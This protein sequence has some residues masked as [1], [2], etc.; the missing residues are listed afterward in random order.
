MPDG[1]LPALKD[2]WFDERAADAAC[3]F[4]P[5]YLRH[6]EAEWAGRPFELADYQREDII[7][8]L[9]GWK[10]PDGTRRYRQAYFE[11]PRKNG[12]SELLAGISILA[13][14]G[15]REFGAQGYA[16]ACD[17]DQ[18]KIVFGKASTMVGM[19]E[20]LLDILEVYKPSIYCPEIMGSFKPMSK[21][22]STKHGFSP[23]FI[24]GDELHEWV[25]RGLYEVFHS[26]IGARR[27]PLEV[28][29]T[30]AGVYGPSLCWEFHER[31]LKA[32]EHPELDPSFL[33]VI[34]AA[35]PD[36]DWTDPKVWAKANPNL[37]V[38]PKLEAIAAA[39]DEARNSPRLEN[40][41]RRLH[42][43]Q[44]T[45]Q[46]TR[47]L[48]MEAWDLCSARPIDKEKTSDP[49]TALLWQGLEAELAG[50]PCFGGLD[51]SSTTD[52]TAL[53]WFFPAASELERS[54][55]ICRFW[56]PGDNVERRVK[57]DKVPYDVWG[58]Q[59]A[60]NL[61][62]GNVVDYSAIYT[63][64]LADC[65]AFEVKALGYDRWNSTHLVQE[66]LE[67]NVPMVQFG[68]GYASMSGPSKQLERWV[69][70]GLLEHG[71]HPVLRWMAQNVAVLTDAAE[72][73]KPAKDKSRDRIDGIVAAIMG[74]GCSMA[75]EPEDELVEG[76]L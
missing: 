2:F 44:W 31:A 4:F 20:D 17:K 32:I 70:G 38:S 11:I 41:F 26:G 6:T 9:F 74:L 64:V 19:S 61:T 16:L 71:N 18:A 8:P 25:D 10:R 14:V 27:Q 13:L 57:R 76:F 37:G 55:L 66:L 7:R 56:V 47:W 5:R 23:S 39:C 67:E 42:L 1:A 43:N 21:A 58:K 52:I 46:V 30:T 49:A 12:K 69:I 22:V 51:L 54:V 72:N 59:G 63:Q 15:D 33:A 62:E 29:I 3:E 28:Y 36:D 73:I 75:H 48:P 45:E 65:D 40:V 24:A 34:Y 35:G 60:I 50:R 68:Q 53:V